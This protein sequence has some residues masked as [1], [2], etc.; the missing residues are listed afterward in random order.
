METHQRHCTTRYTNP[1]ALRSSRLV[2]V[3]IVGH[4]TYTPLTNLRD[5]MNDKW[6]TVLNVIR[7]RTQAERFRVKCLI[8]ESAYFSTHICFGEPHSYFFANVS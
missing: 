7:R 2:V 6:N 3:V 1:S 4:M 5:C 8:V